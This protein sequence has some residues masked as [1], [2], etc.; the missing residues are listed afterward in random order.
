MGQL[1]LTHWFLKE[2]AIFVTILCFFGLRADLTWKQ[3]DGLLLF[4]YYFVP[5]SPCQLLVSI[6]TLFLQNVRSSVWVFKHVY[7][8][9]GF[10]ENN[11]LNK[12][13]R[14]LWP[15]KFWICW[16]AF[17][18]YELYQTVKKYRFYHLVFYPARYIGS[19]RILQ[20][21]FMLYVGQQQWLHRAST[22]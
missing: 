14:S 2:Y 12:L 1:F 18:L 20:Q 15:L 22:P 7:Y 4:K 17:I 6:K 10:Q 9:S 19:C 21:N 11:C 3:N 16:N 8:S 5:S 13:H